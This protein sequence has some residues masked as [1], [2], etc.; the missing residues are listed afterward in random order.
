MLLAPGFGIDRIDP[1]EGV[2]M[3]R[4]AW[5]LV[6]ASWNGG[7][8]FVVENRAGSRTPVAARARDGETPGTFSPVELF[9]TSLAAC[10]GTNVVLLLEDG[11][12]AVRSFTVKAEC[13]LG[14]EEPRSFEK[15]H[16]IFEVD[17]AVDE[18][19]VQDAIVRS[20]TRLCPIAVT[21]GRAS[22]VTWE[23]RIRRSGPSR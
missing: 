11:G 5:I 14:T 6:K 12:V 17:G 20:M 8:N 7:T 9:I 19:T 18:K 1:G 22:N 16:L 23:I 3:D 21:V 15:I 13:I 10:S 2:S 4:N